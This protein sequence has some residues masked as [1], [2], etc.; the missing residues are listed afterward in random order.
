M[1]AKGAKAD[2]LFIAAFFG[3]KDAVELLIAKGADVNAKNKIDRTPL[4][5]AASQGNKDVA[6]LLIAKGVDV[7]A[8]VK[9]SDKDGYPSC[10]IWFR[11]IRLGKPL[12]NGIDVFI[13]PGSLTCLI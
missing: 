4:H 6:E 1:V 8:K 3:G 2:T 12:P 9:I 13:A 7:N 5:N 11:L 10:I